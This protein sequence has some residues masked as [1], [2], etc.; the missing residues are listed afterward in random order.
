MFNRN[1]HHSRC[2]RGRNQNIGPSQMMPTQF[3]PPQFSP[4]EQ[5][6][7]TNVMRTVVPHVHPAHVTTVNQHVI[8][9]QHYFPV[10]ES[11]VNQCCENHMICGMPPHHNWGQQPRY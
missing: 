7:R 6:V 10:T 11:V 9:H 5:V 8:D 4:Q 1:R 2:C 3:D